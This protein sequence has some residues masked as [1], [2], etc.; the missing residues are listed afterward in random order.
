MIL[1]DGRKAREHYISLLQ[2]R[3][4]ELSFTPCLVIIQIGNRPDS[5]AFIKAKKSFALKIGVKEIHAQLP[6]NA[7]EAEVI[8][9]IQKYNE[10]A[11]VQGIIVQLPLPKHLNPD[12]IIEAIAPTKDT[13]GLTLDHISMP[14]TARGVKELLEFYNVSL[15]G[16]KVTVIGRSKLVGTP[17]AEMCEKENAILTVCDSK[18]ADIPEKARG[19]DILVVAIGK[20]NFIDESYVKPGQVVVDV[21]ITRDEA[22]MLVGDVDFLKVSSIVEMITPVPGGVGQMTVLA[23]FE[24]LIDACYNAKKE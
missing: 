8:S 1:L 20:K 12:K 11:S 19:S 22:G 15:P 21:G 18:T 4:S 16:K 9:I 6:E 10:D 17:I 3:I 13:D 24:N 7:N 2:K 14:A 23:L 5:D